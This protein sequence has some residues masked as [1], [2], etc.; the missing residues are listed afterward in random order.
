M[1]RPRLWIALAL[2]AALAAP[3]IGVGAQ[4]VSPDPGSEMS[5]PMQRDP[6]AIWSEIL[7]VRDEIYFY[8]D[9]ENLEKVRE[10]AAD[11]NQLKREFQL[12][13]INRMDLATPAK[14]EDPARREDLHQLVYIRRALNFLWTISVKLQSAAASGIPDNVRH[15][16]PEFEQHLAVVQEWVPDEYL[17]GATSPSEG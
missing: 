5:V 11:L 14:R 17:T 15:L 13:I 7:N 4:E 3:G 9:E 8:T 16:Y 10:L 12:S 1:A 6:P 2:A